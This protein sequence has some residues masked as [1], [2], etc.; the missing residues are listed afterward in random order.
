MQD[1]LRAYRSSWVLPRDRDR[2]SGRRAVSKRARGIQCRPGTGQKQ[3][4]WS[5]RVRPSGFL[6]FSVDSR[7]THVNTTALAT[8]EE[9]ESLDA[10]II[11]CSSCLDRVLVNEIVKTDK[12][13]LFSGQDG[14]LVAASFPCWASAQRLPAC[15]RSVRFAVRVFMHR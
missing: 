5:E 4:L 10:L 3:C 11:L 7:A 15:A 6:F 13:R 12:F 8:C 9:I 1:Q 14:C 2:L